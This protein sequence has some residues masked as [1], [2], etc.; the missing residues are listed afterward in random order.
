MNLDRIRSLLPWRRPK[1]QVLVVV[2]TERGEVVVP[3]ESL[4]V[5]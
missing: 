4:R 2:V 3:L 5:R 1:A